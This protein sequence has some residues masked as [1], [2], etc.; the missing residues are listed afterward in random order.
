[1]SN[2]CQPI[3]RVATYR[4]ASG[5]CVRYPIRIGITARLQTNENV[6][7]LF[8]TFD[9]ISRSQSNQSSNNNAHHHAHHLGHH[10]GIGNHVGAGGN[11]SHHRSTATL[12]STTVQAVRSSLPGGATL[13]PGGSSSRSSSFGSSQRTGSNL[14]ITPSVT[15]TP[16]SAPAPGKLRHVSLRR[17]EREWWSSAQLF[18]PVVD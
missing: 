15:I 5:M 2:H 3:R 10:G 4:P 16:T 7:L 12:G 6:F 14:S 18:E 17:S 1:M 8:G 9:R 13:T 11:S